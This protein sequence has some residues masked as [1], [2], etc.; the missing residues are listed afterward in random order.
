MEEEA[1]Q[2]SPYSDR[3]EQRDH[4]CLYRLRMQVERFSQLVKPDRIALHFSMR[5]KLKRAGIQLRSALNFK[6]EVPG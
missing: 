1:S 5:R 3:N 6:N 4:S 2:S